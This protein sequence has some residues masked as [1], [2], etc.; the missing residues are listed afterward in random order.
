MN[1][2]GYGEDY[3][4][5]P[6]LN[7][8]EASLRACFAGPG[9]TTAKLFNPDEL[10]VNHDQRDRCTP[11]S[12][13][14]PVICR[15]KDLTVLFTQR[16]PHLKSHGGQICFPG[17]KLEP[18]DPSPEAAALREAREEV[19]LA[20]ESV[21]IV[22][23]MGIYRTISGFDITPVIGIIKQLPTL[24]IEENEVADIFEVPL[25]FLMDPGNYGMAQRRF[26]GHLRTF[27]TVPYEHHL[28]WGAT[29]GMLYCLYE[30]LQ[31]EH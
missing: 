26:E 7:P 16:Q 10:T 4:P 8:T 25:S 31:R 18:S 19:G 23:K 14:V 21:E 30:L 1:D 13:L 6:P 28:I 20:P 29:A 24:T 5:A 2:N 17:G 11:A 3:P 12:V 15:Q 27:Y 9:D 22:G